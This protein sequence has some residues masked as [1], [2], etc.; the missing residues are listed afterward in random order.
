MSEAAFPLCAALL[1]DLATRTVPSYAYFDHHHGPHSWSV[2][3]P[4]GDL[5]AEDGSAE[6]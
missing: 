2:T 6:G 5:I 4:L 3:D 1:R